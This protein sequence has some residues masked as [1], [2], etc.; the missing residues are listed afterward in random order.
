VGMD[1]VK[2]NITEMG[3][4]V[5]ILS[6]SGVGST[7]SI[8]LPLTL[9]ILDGMSVSLGNST[10]V[11]PLNQIIETLQPIAGDL[12][13]L[14]NEGAMVQVRDDYLPIIALHKLF[15]IETNISNPTEGVLVLIEAQ[16]KKAA[17]LVDALVGQQQVVVKSIETN[18][19]KITGVSGA[20]ILGDGSVAMIIDVPTIIKQGQQRI[21]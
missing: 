16:G 15:N 12:K 9:A 19:R 10:F 2:R 4:E 7:I 1:V 13:T 17:L 14:A 11:I 20:T 5:S 8:R 3:G 21:H 18:F 6:H